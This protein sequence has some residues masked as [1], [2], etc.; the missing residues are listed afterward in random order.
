MN[1]KQKKIF[2]FL[3]FFNILVLS[4]ELI[5]LSTI[6]PIIYSLNNDL[7]LLDKYHFLNEILR[8][9]S[10]YS[11]HPATLFLFVLAVVIIL[12]NIILAF[13]TFIESKF[14]FETQEQ[15][16][17]NL[18][19]NLI[20]KNYAYHVANNSADL[21]TRVR[22]DGLMIREVIYSFH[23]LLKSVFFLTS[24]FFFLL[25]IDPLGF[26]L[27]TTTFIFIGL[28]FYG[29]T[30]RRI[31]N[32]GEARQKVEIERTQKLQES[33]GGIKDIKT[34]LKNNIFIERYDDLAK[35]IAKVYSTRD[36]LAKL[37]RIF[38]EVLIVIVVTL[39]T[40]F[41]L[42]QS[43]E[44]SEIIAILSVFGLTSMKALPYMS[45]LLISINSLKFSKKA[46]D[47]YSDNIKLP[48]KS[49]ELDSNSFDSQY[50]KKIEFKKVSFKY[51][52]QNHFVFNDV[53]FKF[54]I[55][56][57]IEIK[58]PTGV[59]KSTL[60]DIILG[61]QKTSGSE[62]LINDK[63]QNKLPDNWLKNFSY[64]PQS[65]FLFDT[66]I[67]NNITMSETN[68]NFNKELFDKAI[69]ISEINEFLNILPKKED[70]FIGELGSHLSGGQKQRI[71]IA[72]AI[73][74]NSKIIIF[75]EATNA[76]DLNTE[77]RIYNNLSKY[78]NDKIL[79]LVNHREMSKLPIN[80][81]LSIKNLKL[82][83]ESI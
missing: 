71:G 43:R 27:S 19:S 69:Q 77:T 33:F 34:F 10:E 30:S 42:S 18:F 58:G 81:K 57:K 73:Y 23:K 9:F 51:P 54:E 75:D 60:I 61:L 21:I 48:K 15:I 55:G 50:L 70:T 46:V 39:F 45:N 38:L 12:K 79:I 53:N 68:K 32:L 4:L 14:I 37:P 78:F 67:R 76:I 31:S 35:T 47:Y 26:L 66:S 59:G 82:H 80:K 8:I 65:I 7:A 49:E 25:F 41:L 36:F 83:M 3:F 52:N 56:D 40:I 1:T 44:N 28:L 72:R 64:V 16:S 63:S 17:S 74:K 20:N 2:I 62:I 11:L 6:F 5:S 29:Y 13:Y 24:I 22:T